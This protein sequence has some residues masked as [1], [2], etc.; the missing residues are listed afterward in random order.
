M[1]TYI[2]GTQRREQ[3]RLA[4]LN[5]L[6]NA[7]FLRFLDVPRGARVLEVGS[8][9]GILASDV[10]SAADDVRVVGVERS[11]EQIT[12]A[13][14]DA[15]VGYVQADAHALGFP[16]AS[17]DL[18]YGRYI[19]EHVANPERVLGEM[20]RVTRAG[21]RVAVCENDIT[22]FRVDP[23]CLTFEH[24]WQAFERYQKS[25]GGDGLIGRRLFRLFRQAGFS[26]IELSVQ[27]EAHW[28]GSPEFS[29]WIQNLIGN[30]DSARQGLVAATFCNEAEIETA[31]AEL[32]AV[33]CDPNASSHFMWNRA[34]A[35]KD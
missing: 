6:T 5:R 19:L 13:V 9:L 22:L 7:A 1:S 12:S 29:A 18:V 15:R 16:D 11:R 30:I 27:P 26:R 32:T 34:V 8:G 20:R 23:P 10:A 3:E 4:A 14:N 33:G 24:V 2:H 17:F 31:I 25:L 28:H 35:F 21:G